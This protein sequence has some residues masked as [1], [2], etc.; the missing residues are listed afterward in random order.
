[1]CGVDC[2]AANIEDVK[3][4]RKQKGFQWQKCIR[5]KDK[6]I[7]SSN[8]LSESISAIASCIMKYHFPVVRRVCVLLFMF[9]FV[10]L[11]ILMQKAKYFHRLYM[12]AEV[13]FSILHFL[14]LTF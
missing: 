9:Q 1:M 12:V 10:D 3:Y 4:L 14:S 8:F 2:T 6:L 13:H 7:N 5:E 11:E